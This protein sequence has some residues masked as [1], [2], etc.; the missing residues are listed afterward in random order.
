MV[1]ADNLALAGGDVQ[2]LIRNLSRCDDAH[3]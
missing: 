2:M 1:F 3:H